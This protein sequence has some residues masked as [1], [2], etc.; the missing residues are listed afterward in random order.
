MASASVIG[1][2]HWTVNDIVIAYIHFEVSAFLWFWL[3]AEDFWLITIFQQ[4]LTRPKLIGSCLHWTHL[5]VILLPGWVY[6]RIYL[7]FATA[8]SS[9]S[10]F[11]II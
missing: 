8:T 2:I 9:M 6:T 3:G 5:Q 4:L 10:L 1:V 7:N 11:L